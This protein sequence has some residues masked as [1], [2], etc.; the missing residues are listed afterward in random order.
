MSAPAGRILIVSD[1]H[2]A[3]PG[4]GAGSAE[5][6]RPLWEGASEVIFN[7]DV[8]EIAD[9]RL[10]GEAARQVLALQEYAEVD[11][12]KLTFIS[13]N[14]D[15][16][17]TDRR[18]L[19][20]AEREVFLTHG[21]ILHPA[22]SPWTDHAKH[23]QALHADAVLSL[24]P[25]KARDI[26]HQLAACQHASVVQWDHFVTK[27]HEG[28]EKNALRRGLERFGLGRKIERR[29]SQGVKVFK[30]LYYWHTIPRRAMGF[31]RRFAPESRFFIFGHIH[32]AG[33]WHDPNALTVGTD[34]IV[35][36]GGRYIINTGAYQTPRN[37][38]AVVIEGK[39]LSVWPI[40]YNLKGHRFADKPL[41]EYSLNHEAVAATVDGADR[42]D[43]AVAA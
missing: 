38:R 39:Q 24:D 32:R 41:A 21:D 27:P 23:L 42:D 2:L 43:P 16:L 20:L 33:I 8:A 29:S 34:V 13:G 25:D 10:R 35:P 37:P 7:G 14:H 1:T 15:P 4:R 31:A 17:L 18:Y 36:E 19:R 40:R 9:Q 22:I 30:A 28:L 11:G 5:A 26:D 3:N 6:L 12:V